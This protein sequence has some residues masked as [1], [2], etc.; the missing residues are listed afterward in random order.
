MKPRLEIVSVD[1]SIYV[2]LKRIVYLEA[3]GSYTNVYALEKRGEITSYVQSRP[4][5]TF[6][7]LEQHGFLR[8]H[9][10]F[11]VHKR[12]VSGLGRNRTLYLSAPENFKIVV[13]KA[14]WKM[15]KEQLSKQLVLPLS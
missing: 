4:I 7:N 13:P 3:A 9:R 15:V 2:R 6:M 10:S 11:I 8:V 12:Y 1:T 5:G 14:K